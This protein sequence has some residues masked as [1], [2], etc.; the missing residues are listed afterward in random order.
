MASAIVIG[1][2]WAG[3]SCGLRLAQAGYQVTVLEQS[4]RIGGRASSFND[5]K[6]N[7]VLDNGQHLFMGCYKEALAMLRLV[8]TYDRLRFQEKLA[9][10]FVDRQARVYHLN[11]PNLPSPFHLFAGLLK[12]KSLS[13]GEKMAMSKVQKAVAEWNGNG[14]LR[15]RT[16]EEWLKGLG[17]SERSRKY[18]WDLITVAALNEQSAVAEAAS[19]AVVLKQAFFGR[20]EESRLAVS[21]VGLSDLLNP[22]CKN[23]IEA[24]GGKIE[25]DKLVSSI[26]IKEGRVEKIVLRD[27]SERTADVY[28]SAV[29]FFTLKNILEPRLLDSAFFSGIKNLETSPIF[30]LTLWFDRLV[31]DQEFCALLDTEVQWVFNKTK[32]LQ[33]EGNCLSL[34][35]SAARH[36]SAKTDEELLKMALEE[37]GQC[38]PKVREAKLLQSLIQREKNATLSPKVG[39]QSFRPSQKTP[40]PNFFLCGDW[41][42]TGLPATIESAALSGVLA[43]RAIHDPR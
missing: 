19:L 10:D 34:V 35:I 17:Q 25:N 2:G 20:P 22:A 27:G 1:A 42:D 30:S 18:F 31:M 6:S 3:L 29:P 39:Y 36:L 41:T 4:K 8:G 9:V 13:F 28:V 37:L 32:I 21:S 40:V 14:S 33:K 15:D 23:Y 38:L 5:A 26:P 43:F 24:R 11:C 16:V 7:A 12:L